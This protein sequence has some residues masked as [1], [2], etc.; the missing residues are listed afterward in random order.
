MIHRSPDER[1]P[2]SYI[3]GFTKRQAFDWNHCLIMITS[4]YRVEFAAGSTQENSVCGKRPLDIN[5]IRTAAGFDCRNDFRSFF[6]SK[7]PALG[8]MRIKGGDRKAR[9]FDA[10]T[11]ELTMSQ[12][13]HL[14]NSIALN[15][16]DCFRQRDMCRQQNNSEVSRNE[17]HGV[18]LRTG[19]VREKLCMARKTISAEK[20]SSFIYGCGSYGIDA[21]GSTELYSCLDVTRSGFACEPG[22]NAKLHRSTNVV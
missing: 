15:Q 16:S 17:C 22:F 5:I 18:F 4:N 3:Y 1:Q 7:Q 14:D 6:Y 19:Q 11:L 10:P 12:M 9:A 2:Q 21:S 8:S 20:Q 13:N